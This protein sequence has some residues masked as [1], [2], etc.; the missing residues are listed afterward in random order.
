MPNS[1]DEANQPTIEDLEFV[2]ED[3]DTSKSIKTNY[4]LINRNF[5]KLG[6]FLRNLVN[7][8]L[9]LE[10]S[11]APETIIEEVID[12]LNRNKLNLQIKPDL[13]QDNSIVVDGYVITRTDQ[14]KFIITRQNTPDEW[15]TDNIMV[16][17]KEEVT[18]TVVYP[19]ITTI[20]NYVEIYFING[21]HTNMK[22]IM[23]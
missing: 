5:K 10:Q 7:Y 20:D 4:L 2:L 3:V 17:V 1:L 14:D 13:A 19:V 18:G 16:V 12:R 8:V 15:V 23:L 6:I 9:N 22:I 11:M 21:I